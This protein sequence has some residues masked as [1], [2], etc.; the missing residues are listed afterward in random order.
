LYSKRVCNNIMCHLLL[1]FILGDRLDTD[2]TIA[3][4]EYWGKRAMRENQNYMSKEWKTSVALDSKIT[5]EKSVI[6]EPVSNS[7][8]ELQRSIFHCLWR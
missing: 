2:E 8:T 7:T 4:V 6:Y 5:G 1:R 3:Y